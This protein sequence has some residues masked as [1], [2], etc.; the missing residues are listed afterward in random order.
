MQVIDN[1]H[2]NWIK[3]INNLH[4]AFKL[5]RAMKQLE[6][7]FDELHDYTGFHFGTEEKFMQNFD[8]DDYENHHDSHTKFFEQLEKF[9][10]EYEKGKPQV[11]YDLMQFLRKW[12]HI[13][14]TECDK[15]Y[16]ECFKN[17]N[18]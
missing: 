4:D 17:N 8:Y 11:A 3:L 6:S 12:V 14:I 5:G 1:Q 9:R 7:I 10:N 2:H 16:V 18:V 13:H 15:K